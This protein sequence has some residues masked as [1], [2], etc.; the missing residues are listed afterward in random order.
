MAS[1]SILPCILIILVSAAIFLLPLDV[2][3]DAVRL[4]LGASQKAGTAG[5]AIAKAAAQYPLLPYN[6]EEDSRAIKG[7][8]F[9]PEPAMPQRTPRDSISSRIRGI[10]TGRAREPA[11]TINL[12]AE[13]KRKFPALSMA[14]YQRFQS[15]NPMIFRLME[16]RNA[17]S[18]SG[19]SII[20]S[21]QKMESVSHYIALLETGGPFPYTS[22]PPG[23]SSE[24]LLGGMAVNIYYNET[25]AWNMFAPHI[26]A[27]LYIEVNHIVPWSIR[28]YD[29]NG[30]RILF[31]GSRFIY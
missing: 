24:T 23:I 10:F 8:F 15:E 16:W 21:Q 1:K 20:Y 4:Q 28:G 17:E 18:P 29:E 6:S 26:A 19:K 14:K 2:T 3:G 30:L 22:P 11:Y 12:S 5:P 25:E 31:D 9:L 27:S 7:S 13:D